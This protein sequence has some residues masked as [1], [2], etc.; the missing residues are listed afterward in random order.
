MAKTTTSKITTMVTSVACS[1][2]GRQIVSDS[3]DKTIQVWNAETGDLV[4]GPLQGH[5]DVVICIVCSTDKMH[6][7]SSSQDKII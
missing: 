6:I 5:T 3:N 2:D 7:V 1:S 4:A